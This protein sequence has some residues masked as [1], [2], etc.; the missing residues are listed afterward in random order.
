LRGFYE[1]PSFL[2]ILL[3]IVLKKI[4]LSSTFL[5]AFLAA[6]AS[7]AECWIIPKSQCPHAE[8][9]GR[10]LAGADMHGAHLLEGDLTKADPRPISRR[11][12]S[13]TAS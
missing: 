7:W 13:T 12:T 8:L 11:R 9:S 3:E 1:H 4:L 2:N 6:N 5:L 10:N